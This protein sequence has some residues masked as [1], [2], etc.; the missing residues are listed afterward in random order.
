[1]KK[2]KNEKKLV[3][4]VIALRTEYGTERGVVEFEATDS[5]HEKLEYIYRALS[6]RQSNSASSRR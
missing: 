5:T 2:L 6:A 1:M 3:K 4:K